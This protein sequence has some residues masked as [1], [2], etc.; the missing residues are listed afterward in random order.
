MTAL[1][2]FVDGLIKAIALEIVANLVRPPAL[3]GTPVDTGWARANWIP[4]IGAPLP[5]P[6]GSRESVTTAPQEAGKIAVLSYSAKSKQPIYISNA[7]PYI[8]RLNEGS[9][10]QAPRAFVQAAI[11]GAVTAVVYRF[12]GRRS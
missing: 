8:L 1:E 2:K 6:T 10:R 12:G 7:V 9:S 4:N 3:G 5:L 11:K